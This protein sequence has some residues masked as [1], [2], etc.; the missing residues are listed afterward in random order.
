MKEKSL[1]DFRDDIG[2]Y[3]VVSPHSKF[4]T[5]REFNCLRVMRVN[6]VRGGSNLKKSSDT[7]KSFYSGDFNVL[8]D[9]GDLDIPGILGD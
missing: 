4:P 2:F 9:D 7:T 6:E 5:E 3:R 8:W 1:S